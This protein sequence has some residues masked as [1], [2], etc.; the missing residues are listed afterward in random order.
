M[1]NPLLATAAALAILALALTG[2]D[3]AAPVHTASEATPSA[4][5]PAIPVIPDG[6]VVATG[7]FAGG[8][9]GTIEIVA[10]TG[11]GFEL[12]LDGFRTD[13]TPPYDLLLSPYALTPDLTCLD[14]FAFD[15]GNV[16]EGQEV[17][18]LGKMEPWQGDPSFFDGVVLGQL[19]EADKDA[20]GCLRSIVA[21][22]PLNWTIPDLRPGLAVV[23]SGPAGG[24]MGTTTVRDG[25]PV[26][27]TVVTNDLLDEIA[28]RFGI[29]TEDLFYLNPG[30]LPNPTDPIAY[31]GEDFNLSR[32]ER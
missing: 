13:L 29:A 3:A 6:T 23:D 25:K 18:P 14:G 22:A 21:R 17:Y 24:A 20:N 2:C 16:E 15:L 8:T 5:T 12:H 9:E 32:A 28:A 1:R 7:S 4:P 26:S 11:G 10:V 31:V 30:R 19:I 27:Y